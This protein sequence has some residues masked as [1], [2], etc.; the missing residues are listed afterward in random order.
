MNESR[1]LNQRTKEYYH[2][3]FK[4][5][6]QP[7]WFSLNSEPVNRLQFLLKVMSEKPIVMQL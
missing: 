6:H 2:C 5:K 3:L 1:K 7:W 4:A